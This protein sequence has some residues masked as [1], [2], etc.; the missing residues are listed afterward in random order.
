MHRFI[1]WWTK[2]DYSHAELVMPDG[3]TWVSI[4]PFLSSK[5]AS[6]VKTKPKL[7]DWEVITFD[8]SWREPVRKYQ[9]DQ[10]YKFIEQTQGCKYDWV[11]MILSQIC[12]FLVKRRDK[13]YCSEW[14]AHALVNSRIVMWD[15]M[16][17]Y[18]TPNMSPGTLYKMLS[19]FIDKISLEEL[20]LSVIKP[21]PNSL[22]KFNEFFNAN[23][24]SFSAVMNSRVTANS[25]LV[26]PELSGSAWQPGKFQ[27][28]VDPDNTADIKKLLPTEDTTT[29]EMTS[30]NGKFLATA[31]DARGLAVTLLGGGEDT[32]IYIGK[33]LLDMIRDFAEPIISTTSDITTRIGNYNDDVAEYKIDLQELNERI[34]KSRERYTKQFSDMNSAVTGFKKTEELLTNFQEAW[35]ASLKR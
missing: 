11:G 8:L 10:L 23:P 1:R 14:I 3:R 2:S 20:V 7:E 26:K 13:W 33:S 18:D 17:L 35:K 31:S 4:S 15:D 29:T 9:L 34:E 19:I 22:I 12:P 32:N 24:D 25:N 27:F 16:N 6:R 21:K 28:N 5:V 30:S